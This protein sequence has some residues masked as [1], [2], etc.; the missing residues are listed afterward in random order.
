ML[1][2]HIFII[3]EIDFSFLF[4][5]RYLNAINNEIGIVLFPWYLFLDSIFILP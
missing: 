1:K 4:L 5:K 3:D 2:K